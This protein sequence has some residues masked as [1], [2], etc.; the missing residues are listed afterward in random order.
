VST[1]RAEHLTYY[2]DP[3]LKARLVANMREHRAA[4]R[5][6]KGLYFGS[7]YGGEGME[8]RGCAVGCTVAEFVAA[9]RGI[10]L[11]EVRADKGL[12]PHKEWARITGLPLWLAYADD[13]LF[14][15]LPGEESLDW[16]VRLLEAVP[17][18]VDLGPVHAAYDLDDQLDPDDDEMPA[19][20]LA[21]R[22]IAN[23]IAAAPSAVTA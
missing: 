13:R 23:L 16:P 5:L 7:A 21:D 10:S 17:V 20:Q 3:D 12:N 15:S 18:G 2:G 22:L 9:E 6:M 8:F 1:T 11:L 4:D 14:E 19:S